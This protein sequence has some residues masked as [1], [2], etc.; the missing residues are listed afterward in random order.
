M[1]QD[2]SS[3]VFAE[4][5]VLLLNQP[6]LPPLEKYSP[7]DHRAWFEDVQL[8][9]KAAAVAARQ[10]GKLVELMLVAAARPGVQKSYQ[11]FNAL[12]QALE[13]VKSEFRLEKHIE[14]ELR[15]RQSTETRRYTV[16][17]LRD[18]DLLA[19]MVH[20]KDSPD[21]KD[22]DILPL[23][24]ASGDLPTKELFNIWWQHREL[25]AELL[26]TPDSELT[27]EAKTKLEVVGQQI[28]QALDREIAAFLPPS[29]LG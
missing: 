11:T 10:I 23:T 7:E 16:R 18:N 29:S 22:D 13:R 19:Q 3:R 20:F 27:D 26:K 9:P 5:G 14:A 4:S 2:L 28:E 25:I 12:L 21:L 6:S 24:K 15:E 17:E 1:S 8:N